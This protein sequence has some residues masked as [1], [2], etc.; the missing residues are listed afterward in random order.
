MKAVRDN[1]GFTLI[2]LMIVVVII[3]ILAALAIPRF[4]NVSQRARQAEAGP[5][6]KQICTLANADRER[7]QTLAWPADLASIRGWQDPSPR[8]FTLGFATA[9]G[10]ASATPVANAGT[11]AVSMDCGTG[12]I[13]GD[14]S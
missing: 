12:V 8:Y 1:K 4:G 3:G 11:T 10:V 14:V 2:E 6:L 13:T 5:L 9:T 7:S